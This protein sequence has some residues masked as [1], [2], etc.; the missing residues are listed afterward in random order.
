MSS[1]LLQILHHSN[2][3]LPACEYSKHNDTHAE[4]ITWCCLPKELNKL[5]PCL[6][7][8]SNRYCMMILLIMYSA[9]KKDKKYSDIKHKN[10]S[11]SS[12]CVYL[13]AW[14]MCSR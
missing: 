12:K 8:R 4:M 11:L 14:K 13:L 9:M 10:T 6:L 7:C 5:F 3:E 1:Y 2:Y